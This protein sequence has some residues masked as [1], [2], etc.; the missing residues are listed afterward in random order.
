MRKLTLL[1][2]AVISIVIAPLS[3]RADNPNKILIAYFSWG[4]NTETVANYIAN[5]T[6]GDMFRI[7][8]VVPYV[9]DKGIY[10]VRTNSESKKVLIR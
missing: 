5:Q 2:I 7:E 6:Q 8:P 3:L 9:P 1:A 4:G 10:I